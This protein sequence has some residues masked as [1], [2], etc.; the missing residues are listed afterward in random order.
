MTNEAL[1]M[2]FNMLEKTYPGIKI[3]RSMIACDIT[4]FDEDLRAQLSA[5]KKIILDAGPESVLLM[6]KHEDYL[7]KVFD[8]LDIDINTHLVIVSGTCDP[9]IINQ[10]KLKDIVCYGPF[11]AQWLLYGAGEQHDER[12]TRYEHDVTKKTKT[13]LSFN[14]VVR[15]HRVAIVA[16]LIQRGIIDN[17]YVSFFKSAMHPGKEFSDQDTHLRNCFR[18]FRTETVNLYNKYG[19]TILDMPEDLYLDDINPLEN[20]A[21]THN[22]REFYET[23]FFSLITE[24]SWHTEIGRAHV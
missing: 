16:E 4:R 10:L 18:P 24:S 8:E 19:K 6:L 15:P 9:I 5:N 7:I 3:Y 13:F 22:P 14:R 20:Q 12:F 21:T 1:N 11:I 23:S 2:C 17:S